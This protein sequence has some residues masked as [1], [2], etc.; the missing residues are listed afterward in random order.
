MLTRSRSPLEPPPGYRPLGA[1]R[2][3]E[4]LPNGLRLHTDGAVVEVAALAPDLFRVG[5]FPDGRP[6]RYGSEAVAKAAWDAVPVTVS[7]G[8]GRWRVATPAAAAVVAADPV[9][10]GF[11][12]GAGRAFAQDHPAWGMGVIPR[13]DPPGALP[14]PSGPEVR[15]YKARP[16][17]ER[18]FGCGERTGGLEKTDSHQVFWNVDPPPG[19]TASLSNLYT[20]I[21]FLLA[22]G[23]GRAWGLFFDNPGRV[24][25]DLAREHPERTWFG[26]AGGDL[27]YYVFTGPSPRDVVG[28]Y[29]ELT[30]RTPLPPLWSLGFHHS[31]F[32]YER[33]EEFRELARQFR[34]RDIPCDVL[35]FDIDYMDGY[36]VFTW[37][38]ERFP[39]PAGLVEELGRQ[40][41]R[42]VTIVDPG[43]KVDEGYALYREGRDGGHFCRT[44]HGDEY[45]NVVWPGLCAFPDFTSERTRAWWGD[46]LPALLDA[47]VAGVWCDMNEPSL[48]VPRNS[49]MPP[50]AVHPGDGEPRLHGQVHNLYGML[51]ARAVHEGLRRLRPDRRPFVISRSGYAGLQRYALQWTGDNT[52]W[53]EHLW[54]SV[55]QLQNMGLSGMAW[56]GV[57]VGGWGGHCTG[58]L[59]ARWTEFGA[60]QPFC[61]NHNAK[62]TRPQEPWAFGEPCESVVRA[63]LKLRQRLIPY[64]YTLFEEC[65]RTGAPILR[66][67]LFEYPDDET[68]YTMDDELLLGEALLVAPVTRPGVEHRYV[69]L[70]RGT[71]FHLWSGERV[72]GPAHVLARAPLGEPPVYVR[73]STP[74]P[75]WPEMAY[76]GQRP[77]DPLTLLAFPAEGRGAL[78]LYEDAGD[79]YEHERGVYARRE[80]TCEGAGDR[81]TVR[82]GQRQGSFVP[83]RETVVL[84]LRGLAAPPADVRANGAPAAW[85]YEEGRLLVT[86]RET[87]EETV[88]EVRR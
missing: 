75:L 69:Y 71:W 68:T 84:E 53:W 63:M 66:P 51:M 9:R 65:H 41:F 54:M 7:E 34:Q 30:G 73:A 19:H 56:A 3:V 18:Y 62:G 78:S 27:V 59:L 16:A 26:A 74:L 23:R 8:E 47:G 21:P 80:V 79:G 45:H 76:V 85:R 4:R 49:T 57:D 38:P 22:L 39:D 24:E 87:P 70:P 42:V 64:L 35:Y 77:P 28:R 11:V 61:R 31:S 83:E 20:S 48:F 40:G 55:P 17:G 2:R 86:L 44:L 82:L 33:A 60:F 25:F 37:S 14:D 5:M 46:Q 81:V 58:E 29:T 36:R 50:D 72:D 43:V 15:L 32:G 12:D 88:V 6:P 52:S 10:V 13:R 67:L 1:A